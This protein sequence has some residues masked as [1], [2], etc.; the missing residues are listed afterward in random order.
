MEG[1]R[2]K[3]TAGN[4]ISNLF[5]RLALGEGEHIRAQTLHGY[6][7][8]THTNAFRR[9]Q[10][11]YLLHMAP[12]G[13]DRSEGT[14]PLWRSSHSDGGPTKTIA[15]DGIL[16]MEGLSC[17]LGLEYISRYAAHSV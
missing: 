1:S 17:T 13:A 15:L 11:L 8:C 2:R 16:D 7:I 9:L 12:Y 5:L 6:H 3:K 10:R 4:L 14:G